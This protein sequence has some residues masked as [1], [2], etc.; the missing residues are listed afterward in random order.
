MKNI[1]IIIGCLLLALGSCK[2]S[3]IA[4]GSIEDVNKYKNTSTYDVL[5]GNPQYDTLIRLIDTAGLKDKINAN[6]TTFFAPSDVAVLSYL[7][8][9]TIYVQAT[10]D[11][12]GKF[13]LDSLFYYLRNN[14]NGTRDSLLMYLIP[15]S[16]PY[17]VLT[18]SGTAYPTELAGD[19]AIVSYEYIS[20]QYL[21]YSSLVS[22]QPQLVYYTHLWYPFAPSVNNPVG[23]ISPQNGVHDLAKTSGILTQNGIIHALDNTAPLFF[24]G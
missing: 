15:Q 11:Q 21:G 1:R 2:K 14:V 6:G 19:T 10:I 20:D 5:K 8:L 4:G 18:N 23:G 16:L 13:A 17:S 7:N 22:G 3:Y 24:Y 12:Y 9:R